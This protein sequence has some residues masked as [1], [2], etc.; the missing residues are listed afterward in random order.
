M[1]SWMQ[2]RLIGPRPIV[3]S[4]VAGA[5]REKRIDSVKKIDSVK[6]FRIK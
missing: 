6:R 4:C 1:T 2:V 3:F 5:K